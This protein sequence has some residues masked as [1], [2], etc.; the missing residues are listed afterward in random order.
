MLFLYTECT[1]EQYKCTKGNCIHRQYRCNGINDCGDFSDEEMCGCGKGEFTCRNH[2]C[3]P[4]KYY[5]NGLV[6][7]SDSSDEDP[8]ICKGNF[9]LLCLAPT[10]ARFFHFQC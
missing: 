3:I 4:N 2:Q 7:C 10:W 5:C 6:D 1:P 8:E 9:G